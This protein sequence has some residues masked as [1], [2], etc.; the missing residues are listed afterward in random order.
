MDR[1]SAQTA[2]FIPFPTPQGNLKPSPITLRIRK[3]RLPF[4]QDGVNA[5]FEDSQQRLWVGAE[6]IQRMDLNETPGVFHYP[7]ATEL[8]KQ[9]GYGVNPVE[10]QEDPEGNILVA[11]VGSPSWLIEPDG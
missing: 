10:I 6:E 5:L 9:I 2:S 7:K 11:C 8:G 1:Y 4:T 3:I